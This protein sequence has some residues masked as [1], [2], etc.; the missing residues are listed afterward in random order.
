MTSHN[1]KTANAAAIED[2]AKV[3]ES[4]GLFARAAWARTEAQ[5]IRDRA[6]Q[7]EPR[8]FAELSLVA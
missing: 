2:Y 7:S 6:R 5:K 1:A 3:M 4:K 8:S